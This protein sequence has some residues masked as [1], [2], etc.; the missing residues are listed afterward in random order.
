MTVKFIYVIFGAPLAIVEEMIIAY[1]TYVDVKN[2]RMMKNLMDGVDEDGN[3]LTFDDLSEDEQ[4]SLSDF[5]DSVDIRNDQKMMLMAREGSIQFVY[6]KALIVYQFAYQ[7]ILELYMDDPRIKP[8]STQWIIGLVFQ[9]ISIMLSANS[10][11]SPII[12]NKKFNGFKNNKAVGLFDYIVQLLL[13]I[14]HLI[15]ATL[16]LYLL[17]VKNSVLRISFFEHCPF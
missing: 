10:T 14:V 4:K 5:Y 3:S 12:D 11:F 16:V 17:M 9:V 1:G 2:I 7:P 15:F 8:A 6:Q 13:V